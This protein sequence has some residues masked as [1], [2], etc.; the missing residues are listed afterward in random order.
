MK[1][2]VKIEEFFSFGKKFE[3]DQTVKDDFQKLLKNLEQ[4]EVVR[5][6]DHKRRIILSENSEN[7][8]KDSKETN[9]KSETRK[10]EKVSALPDGVVAGRKEIVQQPTIRQYSPNDTKSGTKIEVIKNTGKSRHW[11]L[12]QGGDENFALVRNGQHLIDKDGNSRVNPKI[13]KIFWELLDKLSELQ[14]TRKKN[15]IS[16]EDYK[17][18]VDKLR[19]EYSSKI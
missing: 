14:L 12:F 10:L 2:L 16:E 6:G 7:K 11:R 9:Y 4:I 1:H 8:E 13:V 3:F 19:S 5:F 18:K 15:N 17:S